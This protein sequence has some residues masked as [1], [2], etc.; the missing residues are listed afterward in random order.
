VLYG[1]IV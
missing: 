1:I